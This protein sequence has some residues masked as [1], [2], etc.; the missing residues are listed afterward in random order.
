MD[1]ILIILHDFPTFCTNCVPTKRTIQTFCP[2]SNIS[3]D[4]EFQGL[5]ES[6]LIFLGCHDSTRLE[7]KY[8]FSIIDPPSV[9]EDRSLTKS[10]FHNYWHMRFCRELFSA[11]FETCPD[12]RRWTET[13]KISKYYQNVKKAIF[14]ENRKKWRI[15]IFAI[16]HRY[17]R[18]T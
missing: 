14:C 13:E 3:K 11:S 17:I 6:G 10:H 18:K 12:S 5:S 15:A 4:A 9:V 16:F 7:A 1:V 8:W 2:L